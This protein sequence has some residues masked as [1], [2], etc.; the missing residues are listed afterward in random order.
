MA[1][2]CLDAL[3]SLGRQVA[4]ISHVGTLVERIGVRVE[5]RKAGGGR[6]D[7]AVRMD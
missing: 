2:A 5:V 7:L 4:V 3:Y 1:I 6:S